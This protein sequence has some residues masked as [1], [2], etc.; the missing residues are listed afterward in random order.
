[1][2]VKHLIMIKP[3][4][5]YQ[6][7]PS[8]EL[9]NI[10]VDYVKFNTN[11]IRKI[12]K[13]SLYSH[14]MHEVEGLRPG[15]I[16]RLLVDGKIMMSD[17]PMEIETNQDFI[18]KANG[19]VF[20]GGLGMGIIILCI[21]DKPEVH[22]I[23][24]MEINPYVIQYM[25]QHLLFNQKLNIIEGDVLKY[26][27]GKSDL[28]DSVYFDIWKQTSSSNKSDMV[29]LHRRWSKHINRQNPAW[30]LSSWRKR[31]VYNLARNCKCKPARKPA[32]MH[33]VESQYEK[34]KAKLND[35][36]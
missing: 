14:T 21:Q 30:F 7:L 34:L 20:I 36:E 11:D 19:N 28:Y 25:K 13:Q 31:D 2:T 17:T 16:T 32:C 23:D 12:R 6:L 29:I 4:T 10:E 9:G 3:Q 8:G 27:P 22:R 26:V 18:Q 24:V 33:N 15:I 35:A 1:M 5:F